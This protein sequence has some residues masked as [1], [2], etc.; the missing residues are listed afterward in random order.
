[1]SMYVPLDAMLCGCL[2]LVNWGPLDFISQG[3]QRI[4]AVLIL[5]WNKLA[6]IFLY[7]SGVIPVCA[8]LYSFLVMQLALEYPS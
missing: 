3:A 4:S 1:M 7:F 6:G 2:Y 5:I 8:S